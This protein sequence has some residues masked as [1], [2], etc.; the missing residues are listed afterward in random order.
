MAA[1]PTSR[2]STRG[3]KVVLPDYIV[4]KPRG[5]RLEKKKKAEKKKEDNKLEVENKWDAKHIA[6]TTRIAQFMDTQAEKDNG[7]SEMN[8]DKKTV[9]LPCHLL[10]HN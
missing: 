4:P 5:E 7:I 6:S 9:N 2:M 10:F 8:P 1:P 3:I